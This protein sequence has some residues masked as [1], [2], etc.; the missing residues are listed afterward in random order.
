MAPVPTNSDRGTVMR[1]D[2]EKSGATVF[3]PIIERYALK[4]SM[5]PVPVGVKGAV[6]GAVGV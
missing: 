4:L 1:E 2:A 3:V 6:V 5:V